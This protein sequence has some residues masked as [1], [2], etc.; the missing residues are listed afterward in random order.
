MKEVYLDHAAT[1]FIRPEV[2]AAMEPFLRQFFGNPSSTH[3]FGRVVRG[4]V[5]KAREQVAA[6][7]H[8]NSKEI[9]FT[10]GGTEADNAAI[11][12]AAGTDP[13]KKH[14]VTTAMEHHAVL[15]TC[16]CLEKLGVEV[17]YLRP[18]A[19]GMIQVRQVLDAIRPDTCLISIMYVNNETGA[20]Q[21]IQEMVQAVRERSDVSPLI[22]TDAVQA[23][24]IIDCDVQEL[25]VDYLSL[26][27]HKFG[28]AKG[29][30]AL[31]IRQGAPFQSF[32]HGGAQE[33]GRR[34]GTEHVAGIVGM[35]IAAEKAVEERVAGYLHLHGLK[36]SMLQ[37]LHEG[38]ED[39]QINSP[40]HSV[41]SILNLAIPGVSAEALLIRLDMFGIA[42]S[43]GS[44]CTSGSLQPSHV[45][46]SMGLPLDRVKSSIRFSF[47]KATTMDEVLYAAEKMIQSASQQRQ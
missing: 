47:S 19:N 12:S 10:S 8:A 14:I 43:S 6:L 39:L 11:L 13:G 31:F 41:P 21:P 17:T 36:Q 9:V 32:V 15:H 26:S 25:G 33:R 46:T 40:E 28:G 5:E 34:A 29:A 42:A 2:A 7:L 3:R 23:A 16:E 1:T 27:A 37:R 35:G 20:I 22:H 45:L 4:A 18:D 24:G 30:G 38:I 44:A